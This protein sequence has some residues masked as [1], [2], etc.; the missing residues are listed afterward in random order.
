MKP[1]A[2]RRRTK[3]QIKDEKF[4]ALT[5]QQAIEDKLKALERI[6]EENAELKQQQEAGMKAQQ[7]LQSM[8]ESGFVGVDES[9]NY[10]P[11]QNVTQSQQY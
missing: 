1:G 4:E 6:V 7:A 2:K 8:M 9:G 3:Q 5:K 11:G 10:I